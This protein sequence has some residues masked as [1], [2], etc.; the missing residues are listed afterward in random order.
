MK[1]QRRGYTFMSPSFENSEATRFGVKNG[2]VV[3]PISA[4]S[5]VG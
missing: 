4:M 2:Q 5:G 1:W 3:V